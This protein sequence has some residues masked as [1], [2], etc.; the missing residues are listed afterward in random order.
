VNKI[1]IRRLPECL[2][3]EANPVTGWYDL[4]SLLDYGPKTNSSLSQ[5][6]CRRYL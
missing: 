4:W 2:P 1:L 3:D 6:L 5:I